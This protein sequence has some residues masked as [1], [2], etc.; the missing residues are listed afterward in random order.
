MTKL[1][2]L[3]G[4]GRLSLA[5]ALNEFAWFF[6]TLS[7]SLLVYRRTGSALGSAAFFLCSQG[8][9]ALAAPW[10]VGRLDRSSP[11]RLLP[12]LYWTEAV[13]FGL[14]AYLAHR[15]VLAP[16]LVVVVLDGIIALVA[17]SLASAARTEILRPVDRVREGGA[18]QSMMFSAAYLLGPLVAGV[19][20]AT[21]G[22]VAALLAASGLFLAIGISLISRTIPSATVHEGPERARLRAAIAYARA[23]RPVAS[24][25]GLVAISFALYSIPTPIEVVLCVH[26][27]HAGSTGYGA[28]LAAW[29]G[30]ALVGSML[31]A[32]WRERDAR[33][34]VAG[35]ALVIAVGFAVLAASP[36][37]AVALVGA[38]VAGLANGLGIGVFA[39]ELM[40]VVPQSWTALVMSLYQSLA[41]LAPGAGVVV[42]GVLTTLF[43]VRAT[44]AVAAAGAVAAG[45]LAA[46][47]LA[48]ARLVRPDEDAEDGSGATGADPGTPATGDAGRRAAPDM[49]TLA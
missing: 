20:A 24:L 12:K 33:L 8:L 32:R 48:P 42:G 9:P 30:G 31:Y 47:L 46:W 38:V 4:F 14:L 15:F 27:L 13:L 19:V 5:F 28:L 36:D 6:G 49:P 44:F 16:V 35:S 1:W 37:L 25:L 17:R 2:R 41:V 18:L 43:D 39:T 45:G 34:L 11:R 3:P 26:T 23:S 40:A 29:G 21:G 22:T 10:I 7:L